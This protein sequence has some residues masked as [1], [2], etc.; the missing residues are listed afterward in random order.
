MDK[1]FGITELPPKTVEGTENN[2]DEAGASEIRVEE[3]QQ[4]HVQQVA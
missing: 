1:M 2:K 3:K 4:S